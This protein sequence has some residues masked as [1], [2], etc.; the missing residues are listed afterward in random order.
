MNIRKTYSVG[1]DLF[2][3][4]KLPTQV[5][6]LQAKHNFNTDMMQSSLQF[7]MQNALPWQYQI[8][9][10]QWVKHR[11]KHIKYGICTR[12]ITFKSDHL[13]SF[14][15]R[16][17]SL[18]CAPMMCSGTPSCTWRMPWENL[19][20]RC[21]KLY[22]LTIRARRQSTSGEGSREPSLNAWNSCNT[23]LILR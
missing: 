5:T 14:P 23:H 11:P 17:H 15:Y 21:G 19:K 9:H 13:P 20:N 2:P 22:L 12:R 4:R 1:G 3:K 16:I 6:L 8:T 7:S 18:S 10:L